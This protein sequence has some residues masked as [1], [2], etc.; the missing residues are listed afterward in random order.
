M[1]RL[2]AKY[3]K[4]RIFTNCLRKCT[5]FPKSC[6]NCKS[7]FALAH[8]YRRRC[9]EYLKC[10]H[11]AP[12]RPP[13][14]AHTMAPGHNWLCGRQQPIHAGRKPRAAPRGCRLRR[15]HSYATLE[16]PTT[17][18]VHTLPRKA[19]WSQEKGT[20]MAQTKWEPS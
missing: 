10:N 18:L 3:L 6:T 12:L 9:F 7:T 14:P 20:S 16:A 11:L 4:F 13:R 1:Q 8:Q 17:H 5:H 15:A 2:S 19:E